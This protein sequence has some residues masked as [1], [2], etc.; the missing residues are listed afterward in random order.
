MKDFYDIYTLSIS[1]NFQGSN[2]KKAIDSTFQRRKTSI[3]DDPLVFRI[4]FHSD[5][6][7]RKQW[8]A[9]LRKSR[10][11]LNREFNEIMGRI[12]AF[13]KPI[14]ISIKDKTRMDKLWDVKTGYWKS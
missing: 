12:T 9:F 5:E 4:E 1:H 2:L 8:I 10:L 6:G 3:P 11:D 13:L 14:V 7:R